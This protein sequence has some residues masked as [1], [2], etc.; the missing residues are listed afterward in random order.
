MYDIFG[1]LLS[2]SLLGL[3][4][5]LIRPTW[6]RFPSRLHVA[7]TFSTAAIACFFLFG[8]TSPAKPE[9][10]TSNDASTTAQMAT[11]VQEGAKQATTSQKVNVPQE[12]V[13]A[14]EFQN[15]WRGNAD[16]MVQENDLIGLRA[17]A[18]SLNIS[19]PDF[20]SAPTLREEIYR[21]SKDFSIYRDKN[22][23]LRL[24]QILDAAWENVRL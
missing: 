17:W 22:S 10:S 9:T 12:S 8:L 4:I 6:L 15:T 16:H 20:A 19:T 11:R 24:M 7:A 13:Y 14:D 18:H 23:S 5:G 1:T 21:V 2:L 3:V